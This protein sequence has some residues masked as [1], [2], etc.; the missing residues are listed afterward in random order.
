V[1]A[2]GLLGVLPGD[3]PSDLWVYEPSSIVDLGAAADAGRAYVALRTVAAPG[4]VA[5]RFQAEERARGWEVAVAAPTLL[6]FSKT[7]RLVQAELEQRGNE[8]WIRI[9]YAQVQE[10]AE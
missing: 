4:E 8:T 10:R 7:G 9:E 2:R 3:F 5:R 6:T 1:R